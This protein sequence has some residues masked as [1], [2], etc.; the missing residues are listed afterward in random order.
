MAAISADST[1]GSTS[2][3]NLETSFSIEDPYTGI[4]PIWN[5][6]IIQPIEIKTAV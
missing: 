5:G 1:K 6:H 4:A 3:T 2:K